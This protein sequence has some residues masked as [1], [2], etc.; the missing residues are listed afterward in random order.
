MSRSVPETH[1]A[2]CWNIEQ[3]WTNDR[4]QPTLVFVLITMHL[5]ISIII[6]L[7]NKLLYLS[8]LQSVTI[9]M[10]RFCYYNPFTTRFHGCFM[11][12]I[13]YSRIKPPSLL[14]HDQ[15]L[16]FQDQTSLFG[17]LKMQ[18][19]RSYTI[20]Q[21]NVLR[22]GSNNSFNTSWAETACKVS[23]QNS[24]TFNTKQKCYALSL[25]SLPFLLQSPDVT[26]GVAL[27]V[28]ILHT[29]G[30]LADTQSWIFGF[31]L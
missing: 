8:P 14:F 2:H 11:T 21:Q 4:D 6:I 7:Y 1:L 31:W 12:K 5:Q 28:R 16:L 22:S 24:M 20:F 26:L 15:N 17:W 10:S 25:T 27:W 18:Y 9:T 3:P 13:S 23:F 30:H 29:C 19:A